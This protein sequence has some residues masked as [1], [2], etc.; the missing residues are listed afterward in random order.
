MGA[1]RHSDTSPA[2]IL[3]CASHRLLHAAFQDLK[4]SSTIFSSRLIYKDSRNSF[5]NRFD[6]TGGRVVWVRELDECF[7]ASLRIFPSPDI[8][9]S[10]FQT[11]CSCRSS[12]IHPHPLPPNKKKAQNCISIRCFIFRSWRSYHLNFGEAFSKTLGG[13]RSELLN[14]EFLPRL[15]RWPLL[16]PFQAG[17]PFS[18]AK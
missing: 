10:F 5:S 4:A 6:G 18:K 9:F 11:P 8:F 13:F 3:P 12:P 7:H 16:C 1:P 15:A 14:W 17:P 2:S